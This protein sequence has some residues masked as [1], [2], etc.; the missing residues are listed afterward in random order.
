MKKALGVLFVLIIA[1]G[2]LP[3]FAHGEIICTAPEE[4]EEQLIPRF[5]YFFVPG[6][7]IVGFLDPYSGSEY[8]M[9]FAELLPEFNIL[10]VRDA[11]RVIYEAC[12]NECCKSR[13][14]I[15]FL[16]TLADKTEKAILHAIEL[17]EQ[18]QNIRYAERNGINSIW[19]L[20][21]VPIVWGTPTTSSIT[22]AGIGGAEYRMAAPVIGEWQ[23]SPQFTGLSANTEYTFQAR[24]AEANGNP[25]SAP[26]G[27]HSD[28]HRFFPDAHNNLRFKRRY[29][30]GNHPH[31]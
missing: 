5:P 9:L 23:A 17:L 25:P 31:C 26:S 3:V 11:N 18:N 7:I 14:G 15:T 20:P 21:F 30:S 22:L 16:L 24:I 6:E 12:G 28:S 19:S 8:A 2:T 13:L 29:A 1:A 4:H 27:K 10:D